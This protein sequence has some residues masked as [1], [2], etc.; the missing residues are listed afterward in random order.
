MLVKNMQWLFYAN[1]PQQSL[2]FLFLLTHNHIRC[3]ESLDC[4]ERD[5]IIISDR[6]G[7]DEESSTRCD[8]VHQLRPRYARSALL[9]LYRAADGFRKSSFRLRA[10]K[11]CF[12]SFF[13]ILGS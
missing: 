1:E 4:P 13:Y 12:D 11:Q 10:S 3:T 8:I 7:N 6:Y 9:P 2:P 5:V